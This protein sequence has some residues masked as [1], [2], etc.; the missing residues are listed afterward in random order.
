MLN[1][2]SYTGLSTVVVT[3]LLGLSML[4]CKQKASEISTSDLVNNPASAQGDLE[5]KSAQ[6]RFVDSTYHFGKVVDGDVVKHNFKFV[7]A[8]D[9]PLVIAS[10]KASCGCTVPDWPREPIAP[11]DSGVIKAEFNSQGR[12][13]MVSKTITVSSNSNPGMKVLV[14]EGQVIPKV[15]GAV[16]PSD[17]KNSEI[18]K[19]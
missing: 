7:N 13:G 11:G 9:A 6:L 8:G 5:G 14:L 18:V 19:H 17:N 2:M 16:A 12:V 1:R 15:A 4:A 3:G 10:A